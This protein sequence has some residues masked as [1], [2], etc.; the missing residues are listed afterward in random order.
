MIRSQGVFPDAHR[1]LKQWLRPFRLAISHRESSQ[2]IEHLSY[3]GM[4]GSQG[5]L[6]NAEC[7]LIERFGL[8]RLAP[9]TIEECQPHERISHLEAGRPCRLLPDAERAL[10]ELFGLLIESTVIQI[11]RSFAGERG[12]GDGFFSSSA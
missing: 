1:A 9:H 6:S 8:L 7:A 3:Q 10:I 12:K 11:L 4:S 5:L 2:A